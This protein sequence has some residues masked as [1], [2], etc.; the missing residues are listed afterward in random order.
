MAHEFIIK[1]A[2]QILKSHP[3]KNISNESSIFNTDASTLSWSLASVNATKSYIDSRSGMSSNL[4]SDASINLNDYSI[5]YFNNDSSILVID[6]SG[7]YYGTDLSQFYTDRSLVDKAY[8]DSHSGGITWSTPVNANII[9]GT[10]SNYNIG[11]EVSTFNNI[12]YSGYIF[13]DDKATYPFIRRGDAN[14][15][16]NFFAL[17][18]RDVSISADPSI[19]FTDNIFVSWFSPTQKLEGSYNTGIGVGSLS[20][21]YKGY[22]NT[23]LGNNTGRFITEGSGNTFIGSQAASNKDR[24]FNSYIASHNT[25]L[26]AYAG[27]GNG[28]SNNVFLGYEAGK[29]S[30]IDNKL[31]I[32]NSSTNKPL[33]YGE[34]D[35]SILKF[36]TDQIIVPVNN[37][38]YIGDPN[39]NGSWRYMISGAQLLYQ[40]RESS[41]WVT[42]QTIG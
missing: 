40:R 26:G 11:S 14:N 24:T 36:N 30:S 34:F 22:D 27:S 1:N 41:I 2:L 18:N 5:T 29:D 3:I 31:Y 12:Y 37:I 4:T 7:V 20:R 28:G 6:G 15:T 17:A 39:T 19:L 33:I 8:V 42:K 32:A 9:P 10:I 25:Y 35:T 21:L 13:K 38:S 23:T 16:S